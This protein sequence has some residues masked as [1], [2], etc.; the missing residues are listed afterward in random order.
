MRYRGLTWNH[1]RGYAALV[2]AAVQLDEARDAL[3]I[4]WDRQPLEGFE[5]HPIAQLCARYDLVVLDHP[6]VGEAI[7]QRCLQPLENLFRSDEL[8]TLSKQIIGPSYSSYAYGGKH[9]AL[10]LDAATQVCAYRADLIDEAPPRTWAEVVALS[11]RVPVALSLAGPHAA[12]SFWSIAAALGDPPGRT[13]PGRLIAIDTGLQ[14]IE[15]MTA[16]AARMPES[17][18]SGALPAGLRLRELCGR[19]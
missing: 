4:A 16:L 7:E 12:L 14:V 19:N 8:A 10:P 3:G 5:S 1:P 2:A 18:R 17:V 9:W 6:H 13:D 11:E 15:L